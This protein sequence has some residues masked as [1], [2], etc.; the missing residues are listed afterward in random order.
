[1]LYSQRKIAKEERRTKE[2]L[3]G[4]K[5]INNLAV[6][7]PYLSIIILNVNGFDSPS[8]RN[9]GVPTEAQW[10]KNLNCS[11]L[12]PCRGEGLIAGPAQWVKGSGIA[13]TVV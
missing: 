8:I 13:A 1:M 5:I 11:G 10:V 6:V 9:R 7:N 12:D 2:I 3:K 4:Q